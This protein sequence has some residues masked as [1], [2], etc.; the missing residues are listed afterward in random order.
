[1]TNTKTMNILAQSLA[2]NSANFKNARINAT[3]LGDVV[4]TRNWLQAVKAM[5]IPAYSVAEIR[6]NNM[7][8]PADKATQAD[9]T[10]LYDALRVVINMIG[11][12]NG[13]T[14][15]IH[16]CAEAIILASA[17]YRPIDLTPAMAE[18]R[19]R[20]SIASRELREA[21]GNE[22]VEAAQANYDR[23]V[24]EVK[25]LEGIAGNCRQQFEAVKESA[26]VKTVEHLF[27]DAINQQAAKSAEQIAAEE[28]LKREARKAQA[29]AAR[30]ARRQAKAQA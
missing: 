11:E 22:A 5:R 1:M 4:L 2:D 19:C 10:P 27:G 17:T 29:K 20:K 24:E 23:C 16:N 8:V 12:V 13:I 15:D 21:V 3:V 28:A 6:H 9:Q 7:N 14:L 30:Q 26:F 25:T 18:A